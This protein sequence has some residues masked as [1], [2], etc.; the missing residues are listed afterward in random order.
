MNRFARLTL[1]LGAA[2]TLGSSLAVTCSGTLVY[3]RYADSLFPDPVLDDADLDIRVLTNLYD[4]RP[5]PTP[6]Q[7]AP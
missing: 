3:G 7:T 6:G 4:P 5:A 2:L 1:T